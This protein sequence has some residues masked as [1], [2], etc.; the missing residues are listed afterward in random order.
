MKKSYTQSGG[1]WKKSMTRGIQ[2]AS[3]KFRVK[4]KW[5]HVGILSTSWYA[6]AIKNKFS[7]NILIDEIDKRCQKLGI[8]L[9]EIS[10]KDY[11]NLKKNTRYIFLKQDL[12]EKTEY[13][14]LLQ[15]IKDGKLDKDFEKYYSS[16]KYTKFA[17]QT[18]T[19][20]IFRKSVPLKIKE[21]YKKDI[22]INNMIEDL[23]NIKETGRSK[24]K[25][26]RKE[27]KRKHKHHHRKHKHH[28]RRKSKNN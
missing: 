27:S 12:K 1:G 17:R 19:G 5:Y 14:V 3:D 20:N 11:D 2:A 15:N 6:S 7:I 24:R 22:S 18:E 9:R 28:S 26:K 8:Y 4:S 23:E 10:S 13:D 21:K 25:S 16:F